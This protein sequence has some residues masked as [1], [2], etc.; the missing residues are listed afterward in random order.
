MYQSIPEIPER[1]YGTIARLNDSWGEKYA[2]FAE[3]ALL[4]PKD[5]MESQAVAA[6]KFARWYDRQA[7]ARWNLMNLSGR[8]VKAYKE[9]D[10]LAVTGFEGTGGF[11][12]D[13]N[14]IISINTFYSPYPSIGDDILRSI[15]DRSLIRANWMGYSKTGDAL[16]DA[17]WRMVMKEMDSIW[18]WMWSGA[19]SYRG[20][21]T[22]TLDFYDCTADLT[23]EMKPVR[24]GLGDLLLKLKPRHSRIAIYY[25]VPSAITAALKTA[26]A[27]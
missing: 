26:P 27:S 10:P 17:A 25:S 14:N 16:S 9:L 8:F 12:D 6:G 5:N 23:R 3:V 24:E 1:Q 20:Y 21:L 11:G 15:A 19:G 18:Y 2:S 7:F 4:D 13:I 22:P